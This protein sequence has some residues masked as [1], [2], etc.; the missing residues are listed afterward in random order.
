MGPEQKS[1]VEKAIIKARWKQI[2]NF[3]KKDQNGYYL[4]QS[5]VPQLMSYLSDLNFW[6][7]NQPRDI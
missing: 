6:L 5:W 3:P 4:W 1:A 7:W 2:Y